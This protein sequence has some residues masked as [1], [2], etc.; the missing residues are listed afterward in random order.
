MKIPQR[1]DRRIGASVLARVLDP[2]SGLLVI[3]IEERGAGEG[4]LDRRVQVAVGAEVGPIDEG[5]ELVAGLAVETAVRLRR[6][7]DD[8]TRSGDRCV[9]LFGDL[10]VPVAVG[11]ASLDAPHPCGDRVD[12]SFPSD[13]ARTLVLRLD[14]PSR[15]SEDV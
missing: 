1:A 9:F 6:D 5:G 10:D 13:P 11:F 2:L 4:H 12:L 14:G 8:D 3:A 15:P 7:L